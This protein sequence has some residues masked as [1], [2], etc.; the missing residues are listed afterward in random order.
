M[1]ATLAKAPG[2]VDTSLAHHV[3]YQTLPFDGF[4]L[5]GGF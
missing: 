5:T 1:A 2:P 3:H 4:A